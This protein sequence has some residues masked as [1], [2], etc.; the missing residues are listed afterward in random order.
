MYLEFHFVTLF[1]CSAFAVLSLLLCNDSEAHLELAMFMFSVPLISFLAFSSFSNAFLVSY[2]WSE[3]KWHFEICTEK[4]TFLN[5][6]YYRPVLM[7][8]SECLLI[9]HVLHT[10]A[11]LTGMGGRL[12]E[13]LS[14]PHYCF[15]TCVNPCFVLTRPLF[16]E[17]HLASPSNFGVSDSQ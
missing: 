14:S 16:G 3:I 2:Y 13:S 11:E 12:K 10:D 5:L 7:N 8:W 1:I 15:W 6:H 4:K 9:L 17:L